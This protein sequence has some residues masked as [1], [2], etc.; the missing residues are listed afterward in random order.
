MTKLLKAASFPSE[1]GALSQPG[2]GQRKEEGGGECLLLRGQTCHFE[3][4]WVWNE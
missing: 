2:A 1:S 3:G 4:L